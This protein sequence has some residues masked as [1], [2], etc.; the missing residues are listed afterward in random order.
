[1]RRRCLALPRRPAFALAVAV[2]RGV[3]LALAAI[4]PAP[5]C[6]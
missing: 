6:P 5:E 4:R 2:L 3:L 1:M